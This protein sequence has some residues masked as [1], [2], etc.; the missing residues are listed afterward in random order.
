LKKN[1][2]LF[3]LIGI[4]AISSLGCSR[5]FIFSIL[6]NIPF[7]NIQ[8]SDQEESS[9]TNVETSE[10]NNGNSDQM[11]STP[12]NATQFPTPTSSNMPDNPGNLNS[13]R[14]TF[15]T[16]LSGL[17]QNGMEVKEKTTISQEVIQDLGAFHFK[18]IS[19][20]NQ[21]QKQN[22]DI[23]TIDFQNYFWDQSLE[24]GDDSTCISYSNVTGPDQTT[25][26][27]DSLSP[28]HFFKDV[29]RDELI[30]E[31]VAVN[32]ILT[33]H[34]SVSDS[35]FKGS[36]L[37]T[38]KAEI[39]F[40]QQGDYVVRFYGEAEGETSSLINNDNTVNGRLTWEYDLH[41]A[42]RVEK[43]ELPAKC[44]SSSKD[45]FG[46]PLPENA[47]NINVFESLISFTS[48]EEPAILADFFV[49]NLSENGFSQKDYSE[50]ENVYII[51]FEKED[52]TYTIMIS[53]AENGGSSAVISTE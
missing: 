49:K 21:L 35:S 32:D 11:E 34:Y 29:K 40:A 47:Q 48:M 8:N 7:V 44:L 16:S 33:N 10:P 9:F 18:L 52:K 3:F 28:E 43:I 42:N 12:E 30:E 1:R 19:E 14:T 51:V 53:P 41:D 5:N 25:F 37:Q 26:N 2:V 46:I 20:S 45:N 39:W 27:F 24:F 50:F 17:D 4:L 36:N 38:K 22:I 6:E 13:Y 15:T 31:G 23:Y